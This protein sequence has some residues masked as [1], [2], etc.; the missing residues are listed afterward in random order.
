MNYMIVMILFLL[1]ILFIFYY[2]NNNENFDDIKKV[3][4]CIYGQ[5]RNYKDGYKRIKKIIE[6]NKDIQFDFFIIVG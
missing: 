2:A 4:I 3:A 6:K 1:I 5:P